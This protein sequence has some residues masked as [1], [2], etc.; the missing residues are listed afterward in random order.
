MRNRFFSCIAI[1]LLITALFISC[2]KG[3]VTEVP[4]AGYD[5]ILVIG[6]SN[7]HCGLVY[8]S[9]LDAPHKDIKQ[10]GRFGESDLEIIEATEP[11]DH[12]TRYVGNIGFAMTFAKRYL[13]KHLK[14]GRKILIIPGGRAGSGFY[15]HFWGVGDTLYNDAVMRSNFVLNNTG[16]EMVAILWHQGESDITNPDYQQL[17]DSM[18]VNFRRDIVGSSVT[19]FILGGMVPYWVN[20]DTNRI[21]LNNIIENTVNR[22]ERTGYANPLSPY[23]IEKPDNNYYDVH[24]DAAGLREMGRRYFSE[25]ERITK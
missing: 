16:N 21:S 2:E 13:E 15:S 19:P 3:T 22:I 11:M 6:Q 4:F 8:D 7:T 1:L 10:L 5:V 24:F 17:I 14:P 25:Y 20:Q 18:I 12:H 9:I 23:L